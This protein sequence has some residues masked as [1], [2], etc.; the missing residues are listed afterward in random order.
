MTTDVEAFLRERTALISS[1]PAGA[2][3]A[4]ELSDL[5]DRAVS[6]IAEAALSRLRAPWTLIALGGWG[7]RRLLPYSDLDLLVVTDTGA[8]GLSQ[9]LGDVLY[10]LWD[11]G[12]DV[13]QQVRSSRDHLRAVRGDVKTLTATL[14]ARVLCG[15]LALGERVLREV[16]E[17]AAKRR[18]ATLRSVV[19][20]ERNGSPY[21]L[22]PDLKEGAGGQRDL[23]E[24]AWTAAVLTGRTAA[25]PAA[26]LDAG[27]VDADE[28]ARLAAAA[29]RVTSARWAVHRQVPRASSLLTLELAADS[30]LD[31][32]A[33]QAALAD[34]HHL[35]LRARARL[36]FGRAFYDASDVG[37][38][39]APDATD[40]F[41]LLDA[42][43]PAL[44]QLEEAAWAGLLDGFAPGFE[45]LMSVRRP[46]LSHR[47]TVG[48]H[49]LRC[50]TLV[51]GAATEHPE[52][53]RELASL[54]DRRPLQV[55]ALV[56]D[57]GKAGQAPDHAAAGAVAA[58]TVAP[59]FGLASAETADASLLVREHLLLSRTATGSD[60]HDENVVL[61]A[62]D[63]I[64]RREL[65]GALHLLTIADSLATGPEAWTPWHASLVGELVDRLRAALAD[66]VEGAG[67]TAR[68][69]RTADEAARL[70]STTGDADV[71]ASFVRGVPLRYLAATTPS[72]VVTHARSASTVA[73]SG[74][75]LATEV[76]V[77]PGPAEGTWR[78]SVV[79]ADR[80]GLFAAICGALA[81]SG[82]DIMGADAY[83]VPGNVA[84][85]V[86]VVR[87][88]TLAEVD[89]ATWARFERSLRAALIDPAGLATRVEERR[90]HYPP[91][92]RTATD[93]EVGVAESYATSVRVIAADR[94]GL[95]H[96][97]ARAIS[98]TDLD[99]RWARALT[100]DGVARDVF[101]VTDRSGEPVADPGVL[102]H[103]AMRIRERTSASG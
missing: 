58:E 92:A 23:D 43:T 4:R 18:A 97:I 36:G 98:D 79:T 42:G 31:V 93:V 41:A 99:I 7:A 29:D 24:L 61:A 8:D 76:A 5:T 45:R 54:P 89:T 33:V 84:L 12:L 13:G 83:D 46:A 71:L 21:L 38:A 72:D 56:H 27:V 90:R 55:A 80:P 102:G 100:Q 48:D 86:F 85:D 91:R 32:E 95:L 87:S 17:W 77:A 11:A 26:L 60:I 15:D 50:A 66:D 51:A 101:H 57:V 44:P 65:V 9:A 103:L 59:R 10:P 30:G 62:A 96:D 73:R 14:T 64:G 3:S 88:D 81:L 1:A 20:R 6:G 52:A 78:A 94:V 75:S 53:A 49:C 74:G 19:E 2:R 40:V 22:E 70:A 63:R 69:A 35:L 37:P 39:A 47:Y 67:L 82:L 68:A 28:V 34:V 25:T 16:A